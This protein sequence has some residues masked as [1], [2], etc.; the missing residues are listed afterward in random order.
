[1]PLLPSVTWEVPSSRPPS[2][3]PWS[4]W[5]AAGYRWLG[6]KVTVL[7]P[8]TR[9][10]SVLG[11]IWRAACRV[12]TSQGRSIWSCCRCL[13]SRTSR[14][15]FS[16]LIAERM[17]QYFQCPAF[18]DDAINFVDGEHCASSGKLERHL[19]MRQDLVVPPP[20]ACQALGGPT[21]RAATLAPAHGP[22]CG[23]ARARGGT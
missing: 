8:S 15:G 2:S 4:L 11:P 16:R 22:A 10:R 19:A 23:T 9:Q 17:D 12:P 7:K 6:F 18:H 14:G 20:F 21:W 3:R 1:M 5:R 13:Q